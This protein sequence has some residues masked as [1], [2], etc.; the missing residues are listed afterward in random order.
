M[1]LTIEPG[2]ILGEGRIMV[3]EENVVL[4]EGGPELLSHRAA[5][6]LPVIGI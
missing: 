3:H 2:V 4:R 1:V 6:E 5:P